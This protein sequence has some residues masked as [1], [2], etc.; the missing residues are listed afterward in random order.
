MPISMTT[1]A[2]H[3][4]S[5]AGDGCCTDSLLQKVVLGT[6]VGKAFFFLARFVLCRRTLTDCNS[7]KLSKSRFSRVY[8]LHF[9]APRQS[10][11]LSPSAAA[12]AAC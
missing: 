9:S 8:C 5:S 6:F 11:Q 3:K 7:C 4:R 10:S 2:P 12:A 1:V